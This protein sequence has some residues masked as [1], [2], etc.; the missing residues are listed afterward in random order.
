MNGKMFYAHGLEE[1][2]LRC[3]YYPKKSQCN[4]YQNSKGIFHRNT[5]LK[6]IQTHKT[7][8]NKNI[9]RCIMLLLKKESVEI[10]TWSR[11]VYLLDGKYEVTYSL[12]FLMG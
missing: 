12:R 3:P 11:N 8:R 6:F 5:I 10:K 1:L 7:L 2:M 4:P 9:A